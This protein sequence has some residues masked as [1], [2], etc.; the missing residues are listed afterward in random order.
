MKKTL[1]LAQEFEI[2]LAAEMSYP[3][4]NMQEALHTITEMYKA[5]VHPSQFA[6]KNKAG[7]P[8][9]L[10]SQTSIDGKWGNL[11]NKSLDAFNTFQKRAK[12]QNPAF[13]NTQQTT[14]GKLG[15]SGLVENPDDLASANLATLTEYIDVL[16]TQTLDPESKTN[17]NIDTKTEAKKRAYELKDQY[18]KASS[19][20]EYYTIALEFQ[21]LVNTLSTGSVYMMVGYS[22][23]AAALTSEDKD[24]KRYYAEPAIVW[25]DAA[26]KKGI[27]EH[28]DA[29]NKT[30]TKLS[31]LLEEG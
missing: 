19:P 9:R 21:K 12:A 29:V 25:L 17:Q 14:F 20:Q 3:V 31:L 4:Q 1:K 7:I 23:A 13:Q 27:G 8:M 26:G 10:M 24:D 15:Q 11:T 22:L 28:Q 6:G 5:F 30:V 18:D 2:K 16:R